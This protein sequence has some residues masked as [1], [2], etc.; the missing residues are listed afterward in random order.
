[1]YLY[2]Y[3]PTPPNEQDTTLMWRLSLNSEFFLLIS[4]PKLKG[5]VIS[6]I[7]PLMGRK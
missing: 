6:T 5:P 7:Y 2:I 1:M 4:I 3:L